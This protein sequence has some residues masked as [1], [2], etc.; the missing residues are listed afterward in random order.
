MATVFRREMQPADRRQ[1][2]GF[3]V[4]HPTEG[5]MEIAPGCFSERQPAGALARREFL[6]AA[7]GVLTGAALLPAALRP[8][9]ASAQVAVFDAANLAQ[10]FQSVANGIV[11]NKIALANYLE[12][13]R[14]VETMVY[15]HETLIQAAWP[16]IMKYSNQVTASWNQTSFFNRAGSDIVRGLATQFPGRYDPNSVLQ[17]TFDNLTQYGIKS[18][19]NWIA[20]SNKINQET[21]AAYNTA[22][23]AAQKASVA[24]TMTDQMKALSSQAAATAGINKS[25]ADGVAASMQQASLVAL[26]TLQQNDQANHNEQK[27]AALILSQNLNPSSMGLP[28][29]VTPAQAQASAQDA[30]SYPGLSSYRGGT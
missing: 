3:V 13:I 20:V 12:A 26:E 10:M 17:S 18:L 16:D 9:V 5:S 28:A 8:Q 11:S 7:I 15:D 25:I 4:S 23:T 24:A 21:T 22:Q 6:R 1:A 30:I 2:L 27:L 29:K 19:G 14:I